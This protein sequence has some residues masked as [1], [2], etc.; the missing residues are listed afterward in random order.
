MFIRDLSESDLMD[1]PDDEFALYYRNKMQEYKDSDG[2]WSSKDR[3]PECAKCHEQIS[4]PKDL[5]RMAGMSLHPDCFK[6]Q[7]SEYIEENKTSEYYILYFERVSQL[8][9]FL[10]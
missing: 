7:L 1:L 6:A 4:G 10:F 9:P 3:I 8:E 2:W 5:R